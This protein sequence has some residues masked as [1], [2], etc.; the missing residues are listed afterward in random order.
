[1]CEYISSIS[2]IITA[3]A[4]SVATIFAIY[5]WLQHK[6]MHNA[7]MLLDFSNIFENNSAIAEF[8]QKIDYGDNWYTN[9]DFHNTKFEKTADFALS[10]LSH[11]IKMTEDKIIDEKD[12]YAIR[13]IIHRTLENRN[14]QEYF[15]FLINFS[16]QN[17]KAFPFEPL[18]RYGRKN[19]LQGDIFK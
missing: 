13:Y 2:N 12:F 18:L 5:Q 3:I 15:K 11:F 10:T 17:G 1:M 6:K 16:K 8:I 4:A 14:T 9:A 7:K 19:N